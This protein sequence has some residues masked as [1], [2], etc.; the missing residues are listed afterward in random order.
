[1]GMAHSMQGTQRGDPKKCVALVADIV[2]GE[3]LAKGRQMPDTLAMGV[4]AVQATRQK[5]KKTLDL[6]QDWEELSSST[7]H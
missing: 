3:G 2:T 1:M 5:C 6:L 7:D 4:D